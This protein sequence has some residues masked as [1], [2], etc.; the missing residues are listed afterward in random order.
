M[1]HTDEELDKL[2]KE[3]EIITLADWSGW[4]MMS[5][6]WTHP[7]YKETIKHDPGARTFRKGD[8]E[9]RV[10]HFWNGAH[11]FHPEEPSE[12]PGI[13]VRLRLPGGRYDL[14]RKLVAQ[15]KKLID[16]EGL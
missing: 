6:T 13:T 2:D 3:V 10:H 12:W 4:E 11:S 14:Q 1:P 16:E 8:Q 15:I 9:I 7:G 5:T